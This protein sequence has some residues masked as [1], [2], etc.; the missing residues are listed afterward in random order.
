MAEGT[1]FSKSTVNRVWNIFSVKPHLQKNFKLSNDPF[2]V[3]KVV[4]IV[5]LY[6]NPP[7]KAVVL[8]VDEKS[9]VQALDRTQPLLPLDLG[10]V[11]GWTHDYKRNGTTTLFAAFEVA[12]GEVLHQCKGRHRHQEFLQFLRHIDQNVPKD[13]D[14]H[15]VVDNY[16]THK[17]PPVKLWLAQRPRFHV[18]YT[19]TYSSWIN[20]VER[21]FGI[22]TEK[23]IRR[24]TFQNVKELVNK[25]DSFVKNYNKKA[26]PFVWTATPESIFL[27]IKR[28]CERISGTT[29]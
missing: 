2:F 29:H 1:S 12:T 25:I 3:E 11:E 18:H 9:Q 23:A 19:P 4:D 5:G 15:L 21:W 27:K 16:A 17:C 14:I 28:L 20:H 8:C 24:G 22:I 7:E 26:K 10:Y 6:L 13:L